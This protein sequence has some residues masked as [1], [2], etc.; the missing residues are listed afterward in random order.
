MA[1]GRGAKEETR[2]H[3]NACKYWS[4]LLQSPD[5]NKQVKVWWAHAQDC[6]QSPVSVAG[7]CRGGWGPATLAR[8]SVT[9]RCEAV[10]ERGWCLA[11]LWPLAAGQINNKHIRGGLLSPRPHSDTCE[12]RVRCDKRLEWQNN[13]L[14]TPDLAGQHN[15]C[16]QPDQVSVSPWTFNWWEF[17][18]YLVYCFWFSCVNFLC[19]G[20]SRAERAGW[21][22]L[23]VNPNHPAHHSAHSWAR[24]SQLRPGFN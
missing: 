24:R 7:L 9:S 2:V 16:H 6:E 11:S 13:E 15:E 19:Y 17:L 18:L 10:T 5:H 21:T 4:R 12:L 3:R 8:V 23:R 22:L 14:Q 20:Q 1:E